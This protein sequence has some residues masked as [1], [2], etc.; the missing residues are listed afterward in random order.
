MSARELLKRG[1]PDLRR[2]SKTRDGDIEAW[3]G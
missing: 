3:E 2:G 1:E